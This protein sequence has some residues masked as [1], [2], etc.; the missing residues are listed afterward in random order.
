MQLLNKFWSFSLFLESFCGTFP[1]DF[2]SLLRLEEVVHEDKVV[3]LASMWKID[4]LN[5]KAISCQR[6]ACLPLLL[7]N[8]RCFSRILVRKIRDSYIGHIVIVSVDCVW[9]AYFDA[10][11]GQHFLMG[12]LKHKCFFLEKR[13]V[14]TTNWMVIKVQ[15][16]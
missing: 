13:F 9:V 5:V 6:L 12:A 7:Q 11:K 10:G 1:F 8:K 2:Q 16:L 3:H 4:Y 14:M 15:K